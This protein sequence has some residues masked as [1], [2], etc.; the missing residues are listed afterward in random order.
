VQDF[1]EQIISVFYSTSGLYF[2]R[3]VRIKLFDLRDFI[4][5]NFLNEPDKNEIPI[6]KNIANRFRSKVTKLRIAI[7][8]EIGVED[9][10]VTAESTE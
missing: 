1:I 4:R 5:D 7:R 9:L 10:K 8:K 3:D 6:S 2:S